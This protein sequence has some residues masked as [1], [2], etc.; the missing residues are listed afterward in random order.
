MTPNS[1]EGRLLRCERCGGGFGFV[2]GAKAVT[3]PYCRHAQS[4]SPALL[5]ELSR[6]RDDVQEELARADGAYAR[7][8]AWEG[9]AE[10]GRRT[11]PTRK[12]VIPLVSGV[13][14]F[15]GLAFPVSQAL[16]IS[17]ELVATFV[18]PFLVVPPFLLMAYLVAQSLR[19][20]AAARRAVAGDVA[21]ACPNCGAGGRI[22]AGAPA[23]VCGYCHATLVASAPV[24]ERGVDVAALAHRR[25]RLE[26]L[27]QERAGMA[28][29]AA[30]DMTPYVPYFVLGPLLFMTGGGA[31]GFSLEMLSGAEA[32]SPAI[33]VLWA[34]FLSI[35]AGGLGWISW[36]RN[37]VAAYRSAADDL[38][39]QFSG[40]RLESLHETVEW[41]D[42]FWPE[43]YEGTKSYSGAFYVAAALDAFGYPALLVCDSS[44]GKGHTPR[45]HLLVAA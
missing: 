23:Q 39:R 2:A 31:V 44:R 27:R 37:R 33:F 11:T 21:V 16:G 26:E 5:A 43:R 12:A 9:W 36:Q 29:L 10:Q 6:Y 13:T 14:L 28:S 25:A 45:L 40:R 4:P 3:C 30:Y 42:R 18:T 41:L 15:G 22:V 20:N 1:P 7:A 34:L 38:A 24:I 19:G 17:P 32:Y 8:A 35:L